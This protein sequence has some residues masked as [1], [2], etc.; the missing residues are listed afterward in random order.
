MEINCTE[1]ELFILKKIAHSAGELGLP[2]YLIGGFVRDK[3]I[4]RQT[5]D[6]DI[7]CVGD[8]I[9]LANRVAKHFN[10]MPQVNFFKTY[11]T[12][13]IKLDFSKHS[14]SSKAPSPLGEG[15][16]GEAEAFDIEFVGARKES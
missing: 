16:G 2:C 11:G 6:A 14:D 4:G 5:K 3:I 15:V 13:H 9:E 10:P 7:V 8:A 1:R 12:A